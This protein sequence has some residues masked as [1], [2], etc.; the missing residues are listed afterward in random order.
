MFDEFSSLISERQH[1]DAARTFLQLVKDGA[2]LSSLVKVALE[3]AAPFLNN[4]YY[5]EGR[6]GFVNHGVL[7]L[8]ASINLA[9]YLSSNQ[10]LLPVIQAIWYLAFDSN[11]PKV[12]IE[13]YKP[14]TEGSF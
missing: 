4:S 14:I 1:I 2:S 6:A 5:G 8:G 7:G 13:K 3:A 12:D 9:K 11:H 10:A